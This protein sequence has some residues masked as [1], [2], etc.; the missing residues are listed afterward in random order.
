MPHYHGGIGITTGVGVNLL[1]MWLYNRFW[2][3]RRTRGDYF[4]VTYSSGN[5]DFEGGVKT[6]VSIEE[7]AGRLLESV[8][9]ERTN[10]AGSTEERR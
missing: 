2:R 8:R 5:V 1:P 4:T 3:K 9:S 7:I 6:H 10:V